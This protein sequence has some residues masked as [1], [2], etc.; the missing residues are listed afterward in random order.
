MHVDKQTMEIPDARLITVRSSS[1][2]PKAQEDVSDADYRNGI[3]DVILG[4]SEV[5]QQQTRE[6]RVMSPAITFANPSVHS[7]HM[8]PFEK[9]VQRGRLANGNTQSLESHMLEEIE[10]M[11]EEDHS[12]VDN[13]SCNDCGSQDDHIIVVNSPTQLPSVGGEDGQCKHGLHSVS[14]TLVAEEEEEGTRT[15][16]LEDEVSVALEWFR[17]TFN[18]IGKN[19]RITLRDFKQAATECEVRIVYLMHVYYRH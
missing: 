12:E 16:S 15:G 9:K 5:Q 10:E 6:S 1:S 19:G 17:S 4:C 11:E 2:S 3:A 14:T 7:L 13:S 8:N 18:K